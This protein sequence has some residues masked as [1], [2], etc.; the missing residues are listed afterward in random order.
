MQFKNIKH[1]FNNSNFKRDKK[2]PTFKSILD[3]FFGNRIQSTKNICKSIFQS[4]YYK[5]RTVTVLR[6]IA[7]RDSNIYQSIANKLIKLFLFQLT[8]LSVGSLLVHGQNSELQVVICRL[9]GAISRQGENHLRSK[10]F[11]N[12]KGPKHWRFPGIHV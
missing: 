9:S 2:L 12:S 11:S 10:S 5:G 3:I 6:Q 4:L 1:W 8:Y 7:L